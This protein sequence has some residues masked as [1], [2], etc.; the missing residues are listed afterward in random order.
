MLQAILRQLQNISSNTNDLITPEGVEVL[1]NTSLSNDVLL[2]I[3]ASFMANSH[4]SFIKILYDII[5]ENPYAIFLFIVISVFILTIIL[6]LILYV[7]SHQPKHMKKHLGKRLFNI[8]LSSRFIWTG[9]LLGVIIGVDVLNI[10]K[11]IS[12]IIRSC[13]LSILLW[14]FYVITQNL[15]TLYSRAVLIYRTQGSRIK[16]FKNKNIFIVLSR[17]VH[18]IWF[19][20]FVTILL[21]LWG[22]ELAPILAGLGIVG[23]VVG[24][25]L[26]DSL[27]HIM[28]GIALMLDETYTEGDYIILENNN[29][30]IIFQIGYRSTKLRTFDEEI[31]TIPNGVLSKMIITNLSQPVKR[32]RVTLFCKTYARDASPQL[33]KDLLIQTAKNSPGILRYPEPITFFLA[34]EGSLYSFRLSF[35][36]S[37]PLNKLSTTDTVQQEIVKVFEQHNI[38]FGIEENFMHVKEHDII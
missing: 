10:P 14:L 17:S 31:I 32:S 38:R 36:I 19:L 18:A 20:L 26:Q 35:Y 30:G 7:I 2:E 28:G 15:I 8:L 13:A 23:I 27:S 25:A 5:K 22:V 12:H 3:I 29:S 33:V 34:P 9:L 1:S 11:A 6:R 24:L 16:F 21:G 4:N 37:T